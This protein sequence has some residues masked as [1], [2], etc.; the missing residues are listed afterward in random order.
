M[1][2]A[3][4]KILKISSL[5]KIENNIV[6]EHNIIDAPVVKKGR[7]RPRVIKQ[8]KEPK[9]TGRPRIERPP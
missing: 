3:L 2:I 8:P 1:S 4:K 7:G 6:E 9:K 5:Y